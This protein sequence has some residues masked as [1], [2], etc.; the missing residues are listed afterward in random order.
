LTLF[1]GEK[2]STFA[3][4]EASA[5]P[6]GQLR[7]FVSFWAGRRPYFVHGSVFADKPLLRKLLGRPLKD[8]EEGSA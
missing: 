2:A 6:K 1:G 7:P 3:L 5:V 4:S 8:T